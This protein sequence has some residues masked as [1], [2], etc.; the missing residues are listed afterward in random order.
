[1]LERL[2]SF[3]D[4]DPGSSNRGATQGQCRRPLDA[5][6]LLDAH[7]AAD[8][9]RALRRLVA[10]VEQFVDVVDDFGKRGSRGVAFAKYPAQ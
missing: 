2:T 10:L 7:A 9:G 5:P 4:A 3:V 8:L 1:M 6:A